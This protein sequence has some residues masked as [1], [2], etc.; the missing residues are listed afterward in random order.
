MRTMAV[1]NQ[2]GG[3]GKTTTAINLAACLTLKGRTALLV[4]LDP[5]A[6][7]TTG[8]GINVE[9]IERSMHDVMMGE[10][11]IRD[12]TRQVVPGFDIAPATVILSATEQ[13]LSGRPGREDKLR[14]ALHRIDG[15][16]DYVIVDC[17]PS[18]GLLTF[19]A[20]RACNEAVI[21]IESS[22]FSLWGVGRLLD[23]TE[24]MREELSH[25]IRVKVLCTMYD[26]RA[27]F[28]RE[29]VEDVAKHFQERTYVTIIHQ[30]V[31]LREAA[32]YGLPITEYD[33]RARGFKEYLALA[34]EVLADEDEVKVE[35][36]LQTSL[37]TPQKEY[38]GPRLVP[39]GIMFRLD[40]PE[41][42]QVAVIGDFN[43]WEE[44]WE[45][46]DDDEDGIWITIARLDSG[47]YQYKFIVDG[48]WT[49]D[50]ANPANVDDS[51]GGRNSVVVV[52]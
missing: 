24:I 28:S 19:N 2:K 4:D 15:A 13:R 22:F 36:A 51:H 41:A 25:D 6:H 50:P 20:L 23:M 10:C 11:G 27:R 18:I 44:P 3:C 48:D 29:I 47:T 32:S 16:Y 42:R 12:I 39:G 40:A 14:D 52:R 38:Y 34:G 31:R 35:E 9:D 33:R 43:S 1:A 21:P 7:A 5:Q 46:N 37:P 8:V 26:G 45:L 30:N 17:P 49:S